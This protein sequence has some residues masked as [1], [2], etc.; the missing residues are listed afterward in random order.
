MFLIMRIGCSTKIMG[1]FTVKGAS[2]NLGWI[3]TAV[4]AV[5]SAGFFL[6]LAAPSP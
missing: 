4:M 2:K 3:A 1:A 5:A 6:S